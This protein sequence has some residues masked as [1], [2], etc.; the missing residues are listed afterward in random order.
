MLKKQKKIKF[1]SGGEYRSVSAKKGIK[2]LFQNYTHVLIHDAARPDF[3]IKLVLKLIKELKKHSCVVPAISSF[4]T[5]VFEKKYVDRSKIK[6]LQTP[7]AFN[8]KKIYKYHEINKN[9]NISDDSI[10]FFKINKKLNLLM[11][12]LKIKKLLLLK[13]LLQKI[14]I[15]ELGTISTKW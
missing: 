9:K 3:T 11:E 7:Q 4:D 6:F 5:T 15:M 14:N 12:K 1:F 2:K 13:I 8:L 10:L